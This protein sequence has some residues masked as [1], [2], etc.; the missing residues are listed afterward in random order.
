MTMLAPSWA[1]PMTTALPMPLLP[2]VTM[3]TF[4]FSV[5]PCSFRRRSSDDDAQRRNGRSRPPLRR[6]LRHHDVPGRFDQ[7]QVGER[8][9][10]VPEVVSGVDVVLLG[11]EAE[12]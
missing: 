5:M 8:L 3:A 11:V 4:P 6:A 10:E 2:P 7:R 1:R 9:R 12:W